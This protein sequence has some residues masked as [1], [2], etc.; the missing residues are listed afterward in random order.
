LLDV[1]YEAAAATP[2]LVLATRAADVRRAKTEGRLAGIIGLEGA[3]ALRGDLGILRV[4][5]RLGLRNLGITWSVRNEAA[6]G[7]GEARTGGGLTEFG[8]R[9]VKEANRL[10]IMVDVA[11]LAPAGVRDVLALCDG[12]VVASHANARA[13]CDHA[14]NLTDEQLEALAAK[15]GVVGVTFVPSFVA[16]ERERQSVETLL[17]HV[18]HIVRVAGVDHVGLGSDF[19]GY[20]TAQLAGMPDATALPAIT[21]GLQARG[22]SEEAISKVLGANWLRVFEQVAG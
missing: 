11:H 13:V 15:G 9:L 2:D 7:V 8:V 20:D 16:A 4:L 17:D 21:A 6:D 22:Y 14:R 12:P 1:F 3:E 10:G 19:D 18:D 5:Y